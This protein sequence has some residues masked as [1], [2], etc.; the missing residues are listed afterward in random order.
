MLGV[1]VGLIVLFLVCPLQNLEPV[2]HPATPQEPREP[3]PAAPAAPAP[4]AT[5]AL[6][7][8]A[9]AEVAPDAELWPSWLN[10]PIPCCDW[11]GRRNGTNRKGDFLR[12]RMDG[13]QGSFPHSLPIAAADAAVCFQQPPAGQ[14]L[15][16]PRR[17][18]L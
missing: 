17:L 9:D 2:L 18:V 16:A 8:S 15:L 11:Q 6:E 10:F 1:T 3:A 14:P 7:V 5:S 4:S 13:L 12:S